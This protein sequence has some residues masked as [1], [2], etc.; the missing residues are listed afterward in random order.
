MASRTIMPKTRSATFSLGSLCGHHVPNFALPASL[1]EKSARRVDSS[2]PSQPHRQPKLP[3]ER[4]QGNVHNFL[5]RFVHVPLGA[6]AVLRPCI[7]SY[8]LTCLS[9]VTQSRNRVLDFSFRSDRRR[10]NIN[11]PLLRK[12]FTEKASTHGHIGGQ[13]QMSTRHHH[14]GDGRPPGLDA[15]RELQAIH[16]PRHLHVCHHGGYA[17]IGKELYPR[18]DEFVAWEGSEGPS[19]AQAQR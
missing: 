18:M 8:S 4:A 1:S 12:W 13:R 6:V 14:D 17:F 16:G 10:Q 5:A 15:R 7:A 3:H 2:S 11:E 19:C 9:T